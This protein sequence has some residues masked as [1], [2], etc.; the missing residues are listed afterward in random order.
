MRRWRGVASEADLAIVKT[1]MDSVGI[2]PGVAHIFDVAEERSQPC[3]INLSLGGHFGGHDGSSVVERVIDELSGPG[4]IVAVAAGNEN[5]RKLHAGIDLNPDRKVPARWVADLEIEPR[6]INGHLLG[7]LVVQVWHQRE[8]TLDVYL[9]SPTGEMFSVEAETS[10][11][12]DRGSFSVQASHRRA[13]YS[14]D[15]VTTFGVETLPQTQ[16]LTGWS[17]IVQEAKRG[18]A[19]VGA[20]HA[21]VLNRDMGH[22]TH[23]TAQSYL[24]GMP[25]TAFSAITVASYATRRTWTAEPDGG[26]RPL[27]AINLEDIS[28]FSSPGPTRD[29]H[30]KPEVA[31]PGQWI[32]APLS[33]TASEVHVPEWMRVH[34]RPYAA[35]QGTSMATPYVSGAIA[36]LLE[37]A[38]NLDWAEIKRRIIK[39]ARTD[40]FTKPSWNSRWGYG[41]LDVEGLLKVESGP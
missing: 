21:W 9:R 32:L 41:K 33:S 24:V 12:V 2:A 14:A 36:L 18:N 8:D 26:R 25:G 31:A 11:A 22:F 20:I 27:D 29:R 39:S 40:R 15:H 1:T 16:L 34:D 17:I 4:R 19:P 6:M 38:P 13:G 10:T 7:M 23:G 37:R 30:N 35:M 28:Y 3:V 5:S